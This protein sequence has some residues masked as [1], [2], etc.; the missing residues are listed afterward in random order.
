MS[1]DALDTPPIDLRILLRGIGQIVLQ[2]NAWTGACILAA[3]ALT[4]ARLACAALL[5]AIAS[6]VTAMLTRADR[7]EVAQGLHGFNGALAA[8][9]VVTFAPWPAAIALAPFAAAGAALVQRALARPLAQ[10]RQSPYSS[11]CLAVTALWLPFVALQH[12]DAVSAAAPASL[13]AFGPAAL[14]G[15]AQTVFAQG[16]WPGALIV[17]GLALSSR[18]AALFALG[19][20]AVSSA[21]MLAF[22]AGGGDA[23]A[24]GLLGFNGALTAIALAPRGAGAALAGTLAATLLQ[25]LAMHA[26]LTCLTA[27]FVLATWLVVRLA[28]RPLGESDVVVRSPL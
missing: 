24:A 1:T 26:G 3:L 18:R 17:A 9:A 21:L 23:F 27:P 8:L 12:A 13:A 19:G 22:G 4:D 5:G 7:G 16:A 6:N 25:G 10:W 15:V 28:R 20:A 2:G 14:A 11:P